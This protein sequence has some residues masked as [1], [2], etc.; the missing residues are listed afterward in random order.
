MRDIEGR[1]R[2]RWF[3]ALLVLGAMLA[4]VLFF[5]S[6]S[7]YLLV[8]RRI[9]VE[10]LR[11][12][13]RR[14]VVALDRQVRNSGSPQLA[15]LLQELQKDSQGR[16]AWVEVRDRRGRALARSGFDL[17]PSFSNE[18]IRSCLRNREPI[19]TVRPTRFGDAVVEIFP[20]RLNPAM[21]PMPAAQ[22]SLRIAAVSENGSS[23]VGLVEMAILAGT[24]D[25][26]FWPVRRN[27]IINCSA[28]LALLVSLALIGL[29]LRSYIERKHLEQQLEIAREVQQSLLPSPG[30]TPRN[31]ELAAECLPAGQVGGDFF[32]VFPV[33]GDGVAL[34]L[35][36]VSGKGIPAALLMGVIHGSVRSTH[37]TESTR[38]HEKSSRQLNRLLCERSAAP[39]FTSLVWSYYEPHSRLLHY[40][41]AGHWPPLLVTGRSG[42]TEVMRLE[43]GGPVMGLLPSA[44][45]QQGVVSL[46]PDDLLVLYSDGLVEV[47]NAS[48]E[49]FGEQRLVEVIRNSAG[50]SCDRIRNEALSAVR[51]FAGPARFAD[52]LTLVVVRFEPASEASAEIAAAEPVGSAA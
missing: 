38:E 47:S 41:N 6:I 49:E 45:Y 23:S 44:D 46:S 10:H 31:I 37:W 16:I 43:D 18:R 3:Q 14:Q 29:R 19:M 22:G 24:A 1:I 5:N 51:D 35:G 26:V 17:G 9:G 30:N 4:I 8:T 2:Y 52:D 39:R 11:Q 34:V 12:E 48:G 7:N 27:L 21:S 28:A 36:D 25:T 40:V 15:V 13:L 32:D 42:G 33:N 20:I 50:K